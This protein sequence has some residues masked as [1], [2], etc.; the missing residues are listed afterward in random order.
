MDKGSREPAVIQHIICAVR[1]GAESLQ[2]AKRA[3]SLALQTDARLTF[4]HVVDRGCL[5]CGQVA[6]SS[7]A[8]HG[9]VEQAESAMRTLGAQARERG[10]I[11]GDAVLREGET[12]QELRRLAIETD[13][14]LLALGRPRPESGR[15]VFSSEE[16]HEFLAELDIGGN[17]RTITV[18]CP[19]VGEEGP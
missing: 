3:V 17:L 15:S 8:Y 5:D 4:F 6:S 14:E 16:F 19:R 7:A 18:T 1:G 13:A 12:R 9:Y 11:H 10:I 2:T